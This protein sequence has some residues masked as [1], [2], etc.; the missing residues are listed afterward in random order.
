MTDDTREIYLGD[1]VY[2]KVHEDGYHIVLYTHNG[3]HSTNSI[4][5]EPGVARSLREYLT[6][7]LR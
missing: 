6:K 3:I 2:A 7:V 4:Y 5:L 1:A